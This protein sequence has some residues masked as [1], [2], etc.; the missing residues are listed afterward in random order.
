MCVCVCVHVHLCKCT[1][2]ADT[3]SVPFVHCCYLVYILCLGSEDADA[4]TDG[5]SSGKHK[6]QGEFVLA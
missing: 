1:C 4:V 6:K 2:D 3:W 5:A